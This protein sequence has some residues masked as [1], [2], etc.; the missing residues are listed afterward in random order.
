MITVNDYFRALSRDIE[1][2]TAINRLISF[3]DSSNSARI[4]I[5]D[6]MFAKAEVYNCEFNET[7]LDAG[8]EDSIYQEYQPD[9]GFINLADDE[10][11][12]ITDDEYWSVVNE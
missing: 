9:D 8:Q 12:D 11:I 5:L 7:I 1:A 2:I 10:F 6:Y 4:A 3:S